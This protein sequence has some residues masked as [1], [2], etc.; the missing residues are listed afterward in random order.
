MK[1]GSF[2]TWS[3]REEE[4]GPE[5]IAEEQTAIAAET[6]LEEAAPA[7]KEEVRITVAG[8]ETFETDNNGTEEVR[9]DDNVNQ[10]TSQEWKLMS[11]SHCR[12]LCQQK[13]WLLIG[14]TRVNNQS[15]TR[16]AS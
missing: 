5:S 10:E 11:C 8:D 6:D 3:A 4:V 9:S 13:S 1:I 14:C 15:E 2:Q 16:S 12:E 7:D